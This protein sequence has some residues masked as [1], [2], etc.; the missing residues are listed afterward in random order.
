MAVVFLSV[1]I[2]TQARMD[3]K[4]AINTQNIAYYAIGLISPISQLLKALIVS[5]NLFAVLC[6]G[7]P[8]AKSTIPGAFSLYGGPILFLIA[9]IAVMFSFLVWSDHRFSL[10][11]LKKRS[12]KE[13]RRDQERRVGFVE[14]E[15]VEE[16]ARVMRET[17]GLKVLHTDKVFK[18]LGQKPVQAVDDLTFGV[19]QGEVF[20]LVG[21]NGGKL[22]LIYISQRLTIVA[23]K[24]TT[25]SM[26]RGE[27]QPSGSNGGLFIQGISVL[28]DQYRARFHLGVC[29]QFD[30][31]DALNVRE[32]LTF[33]ARIRG[34]KD[35]QAAVEAIVSNVGLQPFANRMADKLSGGNKRKL[36]LAIALIGNP[37]VVLLDEPS[38]GMDPM[39]KRNMWMTL[40]KFRPG[41]SILLTTHSM[42]EADALASRVG[43]ISKRLLD[44]G[45]IGH[46]RS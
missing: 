12:V 34:V 10:G 4:E 9:Q 7:T 20:A 29:P 36:S 46:L 21:P 17:D 13:I 18:S 30:A 24:S 35:T 16:E 37:E 43:V 15:V 26:L 3:P 41:R 42:E 11:K 33:Y 28:E 31:I 40:A 45:T 22:C 5:L 44:V 27:I 39:A 8:P 19:K 2:S 1:W 23:G 25:I 14:P 32:Q 38:S 6:E